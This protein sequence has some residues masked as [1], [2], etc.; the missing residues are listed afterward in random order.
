VGDDRCLECL[1]YVSHN[2]SPVHQTFGFA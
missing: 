1:V 2:S